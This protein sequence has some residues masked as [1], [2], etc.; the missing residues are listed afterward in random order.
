VAARGIFFLNEQEGSG[1]PTGNLLKMC[2]Q[3]S[4]KSLIRKTIEGGGKGEQL[5]IQRKRQKR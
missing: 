4:Y 3:D 5:K 2:N 1:T